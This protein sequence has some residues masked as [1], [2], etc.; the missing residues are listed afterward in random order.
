MR[1]LRSPQSL[2]QIQRRERSHPRRLKVQT[3]GELST[4]VLGDTYRG[5]TSAQSSSRN[6]VED[7]MNLCKKIAVGMSDRVLNDSKYSDHQIVQFR[8]AIL[9]ERNWKYYDEQEFAKVLSLNPDYK[10]KEVVNNPQIR[11]QESFTYIT[12]DLAPTGN[13]STQLIFSLDVL[14]ERYRMIT[15]YICTNCVVYWREWSI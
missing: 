13:V 14:M 7:V 10:S 2:T 5:G 12:L 4:P 9:L 3:W 6:V 8:D 15:F 1:P 11:T